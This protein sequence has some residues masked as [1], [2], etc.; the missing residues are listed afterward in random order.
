MIT[1]KR[2]A[3]IKALNGIKRSLTAIKMPD[4]VYR[5]QLSTIAFV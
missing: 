1:V 3:L 4:G 2:A 5:W